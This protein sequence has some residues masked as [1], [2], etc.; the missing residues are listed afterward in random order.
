MGVGTPLAPWPG[1]G[2]RPHD[3]S[4]VMPMHHRLYS[5]FCFLLFTAA[6][7]AG[8]GLTPNTTFDNPKRQFDVDKIQKFRDSDTILVPSFYLHTLVEGAYKSS[9]G[10]AHAKA[11]FSVTNLSPEVGTELVTALYHDLIDKLRADGWKVLTY[12]D[13]ADHAGWAACKT[14]EPHKELGVPGFDHNFGHGKQVW[15]TSQPPEGYQ[16]Q[17][18]KIGLPGTPDL[19]KFHGKVAKPLGANLLL[20]VLRF[21]GPVGY[22]SKSRGFNRRSAEAGVTPVM[23]LAIANSGFYSVKGAWG[24]V[25]AKE[26]IQVAD[27][28]GTI[29][30]LD[31]EDSKDVSLYSFNTFR[32][33]SKGD[34][35][36]TLNL[37]AYKQAVLQAGRDYNS[38]L[39][40]ALSA[41]RPGS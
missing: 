3:Q 6:A 11:K 38:L 13:V 2:R 17:P 19:F 33:I 15:M 26:A 8:P 4:G 31:S 41:A 24:G 14:I 9:N 34:Y 1:D 28:I 40:E 7:T 18:L 39:V 32:S 5:S 30:L 23:N 10:G 35:R 20:P 22:G 16:A 27:N 25:N 37:D 12:A 21:D 29:E 36:V